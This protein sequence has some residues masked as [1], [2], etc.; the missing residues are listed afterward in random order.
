MESPAHNTSHYVMSPPAAGMAALVLFCVLCVV[1][2]LRATRGRE[3]SRRRTRHLT[4]P[5]SASTRLTNDPLS[6][7]QQSGLNTRS[8]NSR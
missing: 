7:T 8:G 4:P 3:R 1:L 5:R 2:R 6:S